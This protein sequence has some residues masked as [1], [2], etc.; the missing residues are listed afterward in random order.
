MPYH[1]TRTLLV[2]TTN[3]CGCLLPGEQWCRHRHQKV[4]Q[5]QRCILFLSP[6][7][8]TQS[9]GIQHPQH[10]ALGNFSIIRTKAKI[11]DV[12]NKVLLSFSHLTKEPKAALVK[13]LEGAC[14]LVQR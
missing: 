5:V 9:S 13:A 3:H 6:L 4:A 12:L 8:A 7:V 2:P 10:T 11:L 1:S 14:S